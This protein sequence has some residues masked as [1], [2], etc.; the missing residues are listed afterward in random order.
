[1]AKYFITGATGVLGSA[2]VRELLVNT[3]H[4]LVLLIRAQDDTVLQR[5]VGWLLNFLEIDPAVGG[6]R[7]ESIRGDT[8]LAGFGLNSCDYKMLSTSVTHII[9]SAA[10]VRMNLPLDSAR[11]AAVDAATHILQLARLC[12]AN[13]ILAKVEMVSTVGVGGRWGGT[14]PERWLSEPRSF[15]NT[16]EQAKAEAEAVIELESKAGLPATVHRPSM[17]VG[18]S[19]TGSVPSFQIFYHLIEFL[20]GRRTWGILPDLSHN[21]VDLVPAD[22]VARAVIWSS[23]NPTATGKILHLCGGPSGAISLNRLRSAVLEKF[24]EH[25]LELPRGRTLSAKAFKSFIKLSSPFAPD[26]LKRA[27]A[28]LPVFLDYLSEEQVFGNSRTRE[29]LEPAG[30]MLP[31]ADAFL[32]PVLDFYLNRT[33]PGKI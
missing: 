33:H 18:H 23:L 13:G 4:K 31:Q 2:I 12:Q 22:Y 10:M 20:A 17:I 11:R 30:I 1:M 21:C 8:E 16:Y 3:S 15:H 9:H 19:R 25:G 28:T 29:L 6:S 32:P 27:L 7:I 26:K 24:H 5:R 14:L